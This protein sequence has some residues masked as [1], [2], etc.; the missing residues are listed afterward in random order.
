MDLQLAR[1]DYQFGFNQIAKLARDLKTKLDFDGFGP[2]DQ[3]GGWLL[4]CMLQFRIVFYSGGG[5][6]EEESMP[7]IN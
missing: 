4:L 6:S 7:D 1:L 2:A 5:E 3:Q